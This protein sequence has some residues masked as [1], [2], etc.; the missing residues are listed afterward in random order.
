MYLSSLHPPKVKD[1]FKSHFTMDKGNFGCYQEMLLW[2]RSQR[3]Q[4]PWQLH[5]AWE[6][7]SDPVKPMLA[8]GL[9]SQ[10]LGE[11]SQSHPGRV[12][13]HH[14]CCREGGVK[15]KKSPKDVESLLS[16]ISLKAWG[17]WGLLKKGLCEVYSKHEEHTQSPAPLQSW[18]NVLSKGARMSGRAPGLE[19]FPTQTTPCQFWVPQM[20]RTG[21]W[22]LKHR[23]VHKEDT[24]KGKLLS[25]SWLVSIFPFLG[26]LS[27]LLLRNSGLAANN[28]L[29]P[30]L[31]PWSTLHWRFM[32][33]S[34][35]N[36]FAISSLVTFQGN[37]EP[38]NVAFLSE[39]F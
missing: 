11:I 12:C 36:S 1:C 2:R 21:A 14:W 24:E 13:H 18:S 7:L 10:H 15:K 5:K 30:Q 39:P 29:S 19:V 34:L 6:E 31:C 17:L 38:G 28:P 26:G 33:T 32:S 22:W 4:L 23:R 37:P 25:L 35:E 9:S 16:F 27:A 20:N 8:Q 3:H